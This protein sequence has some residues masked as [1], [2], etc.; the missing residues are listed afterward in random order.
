[1]D[2]KNLEM[3]TWLVTQFR[4]A[5]K[6]GIT[7]NELT[8]RLFL[9][10]STEGLL[11]KRTFHNYL[12]ELRERFGVKIECEKNLEDENRK[13]KL[14][15]TNRRYRYRLVD[16]PKGGNAPWT[17]PFL[18]SLETAAAMKYL[19]DSDENSRYVHIDCAP[20][21]SEHV[22]VLLD[23]IRQHRCVDLRYRDPAV[24]F[25]VNYDAFEPR[26]LVMKNFIW[27]LLGYT[28]VHVEKI[29]PVYRLKDIKTTDI[30]FQPDNRFSP[31][32]FWNKYNKRLGMETLE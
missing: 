7:Y 24:P 20:T 8:H 32:K 21:G 29:W 1:M 3:L 5:G 14:M 12:K 28:K 25:P 17:T 9:E 4:R 10:T 31:K 6:T 23:A 11:P 2:Y 26:G 16:E 13:K 19:R 30:Q 18:W 27:Y 22:P 15:D